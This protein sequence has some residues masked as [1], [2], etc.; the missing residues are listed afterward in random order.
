[1]FTEAAGLFIREMRLAR[2]RLPKTNIFEKLAHYIYELASRYGESVNRPIILAITTI[3]F[4][5][6]LLLTYNPGISGP[7]PPYLL[8]TKYLE[9]LEA[10]SAVFIQIRSFKDF[11]FLTNAPIAIEI[12][13][14][15]FAII[16][17]GN[18]FVAVK[19]RLERH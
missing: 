11:N 1:M 7:T 5:P 9:N 12:L 19:R 14:R 2:K 15:I 18:L 4:T 6:I 10:V 16:I 13:I 17:F 8:L 3:L